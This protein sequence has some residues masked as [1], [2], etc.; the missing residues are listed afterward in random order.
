MVMNLSKCF[1]IIIPLLI[2][3][4]L[5]SGCS[6]NRHLKD[7]LIVE[8]LGID[9]NA[10]AI[11]ITVQTLN[12]GMSNATDTPQGN[13]TVNAES[14][15]ETISVAISNMIRSMSKR[16]FFGQNKIIVLGK[17]LVMGDIENYIDYILRSDDA[18]A[19]VLICVSSDTANNI[20]E[21]K[22]KDA[23]V[24]SENILYLVNNNEKT[25]QSITVN[26]NDLLNLYADETSDFYLPVLQRANE[27]DTVSTNGI[28]VFSDNK[29]S[30][31]LNQDETKGF[32]LLKDRAENISLET[33]DEILGEI[34][35]QL[36]DIH[37]VNTALTENSN[38]KYKSV[39]KAN[40]TIGEIEKGTDAKLNYEDYERITALA[41]K[42]VEKVCSN[43]FYACQNAESDSLRVGD[44][45]AKD[46]PE[47]YQAVKDD[48]KTYFKTVEFESRAEITLSKISDNS[49]IE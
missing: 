46:C 12:V 1:K 30:Y 5:F 10:Q 42:A 27:E 3:T 17:E 36:S 45:L 14:T 20:L 48:W 31:I 32:V 6:S 26:A 37:C 16:M 19:D 23:S 15:G 43:A 49:Q 41:Q 28:A 9:L 39:I 8:G 24:P 4:L 29:L 47:T 34:N 7:L 35:I 40:M 21:S 44:S 22:E 38:I 25:A 13:M 11:D 18:R 2:I 33:T